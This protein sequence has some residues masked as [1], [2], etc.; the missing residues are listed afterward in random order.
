MSSIYDGDLCFWVDVPPPG[1]VRGWAREDVAWQTPI[2]REAAR[3]FVEGQGSLVS[4][5]ISC[6]SAC[7]KCV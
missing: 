4:I 2:H 3:G 5:E 1:G 7:L 6:S